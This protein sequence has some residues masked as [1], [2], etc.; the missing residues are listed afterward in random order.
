MIDGAAAEDLRCRIV[1]GAANNQL[2]G[3]ALADRLAARGVLYAPDFIANAG[4]LMNVALELDGYDPALA[5]RRALDLEAVVTGVLEHARGAGVT[6]LAAAIEL[7]ERRLHEARG[8]GLAVP[9]L[10]A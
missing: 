7:A 6:P 9:P 3:D 5:M 1:C 4:G 2:A 8:G 10:A